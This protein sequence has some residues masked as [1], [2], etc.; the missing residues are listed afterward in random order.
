MTE[1]DVE[2]VQKLMFQYINEMIRNGTESPVLDDLE[3]VHRA[4]AEF[5]RLA[6]LARRLRRSARR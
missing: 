6:T 5:I 2:R 4:N 1:K 3:R